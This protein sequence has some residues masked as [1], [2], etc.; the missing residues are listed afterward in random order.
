MVSRWGWPIGQGR[1]GKRSSHRAGRG[2]MILGR[3]GRTGRPIFGRFSEEREPISTMRL[4]GSARR[5]SLLLWDGFPRLGTSWGELGASERGWTIHFR[6]IGASEGRMAG[7]TIGQEHS[8]DV[9]FPIMTKSRGGDTKE[10]E[11]Q[12]MRGGCPSW[13]RERRDDS[14]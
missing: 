14:L 10:V 5:E 3:V 11:R 13:K 7:R 9:S 6:R 8:K 1:H 12:S 4:G 2:E